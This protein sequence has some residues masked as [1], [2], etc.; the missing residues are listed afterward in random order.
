MFETILH[1]TLQDR[2][3]PDYIEENG[4]FPVEDYKSAYL[5]NGYYFWDNHL[6][7]AQYWGEKHCKIPYVICQA[8][9]KIENGL[10]FDLIGSRGDLIYLKKMIEELSLEHLNMGQIVETLKEFNEK[11]GYKGIFPFKAIRALDSGQAQF[12]EMVYKFAEGKKGII[13]INPRYLI[14]L[15]EKDPKI[16]TNFK[17]IYPEKYVN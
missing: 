13:W 4:P 9:F 6:E 15:I 7:L 8:D 17:I 16:L 10:F 3:N 2:D 14:C 12:P 5:G 11:P 1:H